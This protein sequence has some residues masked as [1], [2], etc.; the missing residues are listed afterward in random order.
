M[1]FGRWR[2]PP[3]SDQESARAVGA[4]KGISGVFPASLRDGTAIGGNPV[5]CAT[6]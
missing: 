2:K 5:A 3:D 6:G 1:E 4:V